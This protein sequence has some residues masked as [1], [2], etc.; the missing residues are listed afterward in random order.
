[1][2]F[3]QTTRS[4]NPAGVAAHD[5]EDEDLGGGFAHG[6]HVKRGFQCRHGHVL[7]DRAEAGAAVGDGQVIV[8]GFGHVDGLQRVVHGFGELA[9]LEAGVGRVAAAV[10]EK[11]ADVVRFEDVNQAFVLDLVGF[12]RLKLEA[13]RAERTRWC[14]AQGG[15]AAGGF[16]AGVDQVFGQR[17]DDAVATGVDLADFVFV[18]PCGFN[19]AAGRGVDDRGDATGLG[20]K[21]VHFFSCH[22]TPIFIC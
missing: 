19:H 16:F 8:H 17:T 22:E 11:I 10:V 7:G 5:F 9:D 1:M 2:V 13:A 15:D 18:Q 14:L 12:Q 21:S 20:V 4:R 6:T 3:D